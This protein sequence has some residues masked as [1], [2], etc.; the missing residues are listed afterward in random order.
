M[1]KSL[2]IVESPT[3]IKTLKK[4]LGNSYSFESSLGHVRDLPTKGFGIDT[5]NSFAPVYE[6]LPDKEDL[7][8]KLKKAAESSE[9]VY[10]AP[11]PDREGEAIAW[12]IASILPKKTKIKRITFN[13]IT[14]QA[15]QEA[16]KHPRE[17]DQAL[18]DA[19]QARRLLDRIVG[20]K[21]SPILQRKVQ[22]GRDGFLSAGRVQS[23]ALKL[24]V[25]REK[26]IETFVPVEYW[27]VITNLKVDDQSR[28]FTATLHSIEDKRITKENE[29]D[30]TTTISS[31][32]RAQD[33]VAILNK[34]DYEISKV[35]KKEK[36]RYPVP[37]FITS[38]LQQ[39]ASRHYGFSAIRTMRA[40]QSLY[41]GVELG[42]LGT[43]G[44]ITYMRTDSVRIEPEAQATA[45]SYLEKKYG[46]KFIPDKAKSY[47]TK[48]KA[49][50]AHECIRPTNVAHAPED[51]KSFLG[52]DEYK[53]YL[54]V[55]RRFL[56]SQMNP[57]IFDTV[58]CD[59]LT[60]N[61]MLLRATGSIMKF[62]G[63]LILY[64]ELEDVEDS[65]QDKEE[66][67]K[68]LPPLKEGQVL[69]LKNV[70][71]TQSFTRP[72]PRY[73]EASLVKILEKS[74]IGRPSTYA[75]IMNKI[76]SREYTTKEK[77]YMKP[78]ELGK[79]ISQMLDTNFQMIMDI[80]FTAKMEEDLDQIAE[81]S[82][83]WKEYIKNFWTKFIPLVEVA[84]KEAFVPKIDTD[85]D[86]PKCGSKLQKVWSKNKY[87]YGCG[88]YPDCSFT[89]PIEA[90]D[91]NRE[92]Y[93]DNF[94]W[95]QQCPKCQS[96]MTVRHG[97]FGAFL[98]C[99]SYPDCK[100]I[101]NIP[102]KGE[103][104]P[105]DLPKCPA[106]GCPGQLT[107]R[108]SRF[109]KIF[110]SCSTYP[111]CDVIGNEV[112]DVLSKYATH[113]R[114][115]YK[116]KPKKTKTSKSKSKTTKSKKTTKP[117]KPRNQPPYILSKEL[118]DVVGEKE[119]PRTE[120]TKKIWVYI[121][122][123]DLQDE[124]NKRLIVPDKKLE[125]VFGSK[126]PVDMMKLAGKLTKHLTKKE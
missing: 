49:Q 123:N 16:L 66:S 58:S 103:E 47:A 69:R 4:F 34:S 62:Q 97:R 3:K 100:G 113:E 19:Q 102:K 32:A 121:K 73:T 115:P 112:D 59:V 52:A 92:D 43:E 70:D 84:E 78:T 109:G 117:K 90:L 77:L 79:V 89:A 9:T 108:R 23:V 18:V 120:V 81:N 91:F 110:F 83:N 31:E 33:V 114:T 55:W 64:H 85:R 10:L 68:T 29:S 104:I 35:E 26:E 75:T 105:K 41:E 50:D 25:E 48:S 17:I 11:D 57:A 51:I 15:V 93:A 7:I 56:A 74:G 8:Q 13:A 101:V 42:S 111:D 54:L 106:I 80:D 12:H 45:R 39:E 87:F 107:A 118:A 96:S 76:H 86:C 88:N 14:K 2:I 44:L 95:D 22:R 30:K 37:P 122:K 94:D 36:M 5:E 27:T 126:E 119:L 60:N 61:N 82:I 99:A 53:L 67:D 24:V 20:Y 6:I 1:K 116:K 38:T 46:K 71:S 63:F 40:A 21:I 72:P 28:P 98:G 65:K 124:K 125:K